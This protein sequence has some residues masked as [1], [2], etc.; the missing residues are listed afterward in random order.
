MWLLLLVVVVVITT[1]VDARRTRS[2]SKT[3]LVI[4][5]RKKTKTR[6]NRSIEDILTLPCDVSEFDTDKDGVISRMEWQA[7]I[8]EYNPLLNSAEYV[9]LIIQ[10]LDTSGDGVLQLEEFS[11]DTEFKKDCLQEDDIASENNIYY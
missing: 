8:T 1:E 5:Y 7:Y 9:D 10:K 2:K 4:K 6:T 11:L 3:R